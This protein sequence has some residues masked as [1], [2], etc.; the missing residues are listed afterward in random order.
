MLFTSWIAVKIM[1]A[2]VQPVNNVD[3]PKNR[4]HAVSMVGMLAMIAAGVLLS[5]QTKHN[6]FQVLSPSMT[7]GPW[8]SKRQHCWLL[9]LFRLSILMQCSLHMYFLYRAI[10]ITSIY[11]CAI[12]IM[13][14]F[15]FVII[16][17]S[18][19]VIVVAINHEID[20]HNHCIDWLWA[21]L[22]QS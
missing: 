18:P 12:F 3:A 7:T 10:I 1:T 22:S 16:F 14:I 5:Y 4:A 8:K 21:W 13:M 20:H 6:L 11:H 2:L 15:L 19:V 9:N 17:Q